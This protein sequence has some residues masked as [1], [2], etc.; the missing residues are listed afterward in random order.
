M[1]HCAPCLDWNNNSAIMSLDTFCNHSHHQLYV[2][3]LLTIRKHL[4]EKRI[5]KMA[6]WHLIVPQKPSAVSSQPEIAF[7][8][9]PITSPASLL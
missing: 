6:L 7:H 3:H 9:E 1:H 4:T 5:N 8:Q 2:G